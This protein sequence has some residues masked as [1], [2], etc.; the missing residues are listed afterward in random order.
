[1]SIGRERHRRDE[2]ND[3]ARIYKKNVTPVGG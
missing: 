2:T 1:M 3:T